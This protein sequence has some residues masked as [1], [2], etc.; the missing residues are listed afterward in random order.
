MSLDE[1]R[2]CIVTT[3]L[4]SFGDFLLYNF[5]D[6]LFIVCVC[7]VMPCAYVGSHV[8]VQTTFWNK[9]SHAALWD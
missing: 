2:R 7:V 3:F 6:V 8:R 9:F 1:Y 4:P 5:V